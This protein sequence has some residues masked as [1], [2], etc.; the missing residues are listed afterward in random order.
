MVR[1]LKSKKFYL[2]I[3]IPL[4]SSILF[5]FL[6]VQSSL[7]FSTE[8]NKQVQFINKEKLKKHVKHLSEIGSRLTLKLE[9]PHYD[10]N[11]RDQKIEY[12]T[13]E[14]K[15][16][17]YAITKEEFKK[18]IRPE[19]PAV[20]GV[21]LFATKIGSKQPK[22]IIEI[23]AHYD[24]RMDS[25]GADDNCSGISAL[26]EIAHNLKVIQTNKTI[27]ICFFDL[28]EYGLYG[29]REHVRR[30]KE[31]TNE[32]VEE[33]IVLEMI[34]YS[35]DKEKS[36]KTP[37]RIP[38]FVDPPETGNFISLMSNWDSR[39]IAYQFEDA[40]K[41]YG[42]LPFFGLKILGGFLKEKDRSDHYPYWLSNYK[43]IMITDTANFRNHHYHQKTDV[44]TT[45]NYDFMHKV[46]ISI[47]AL[48]LHRS[49]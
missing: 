35:S 18:V 11:K 21:N 20:I 12:I 29:S 15:A 17:G 9:K 1:I 45:L 13:N 26:L 44:Y 43:A 4:L 47:Y 22:N 23:G 39:D 10:K 31:N 48:L 3:F 24:T 6:V 38:L 27:R 49:K 7:T 34:G 14:L 5:Y 16:S 8:I 28:E 30:I 36:Q 32:T 41:I 19:L 46:T 40:A 2:A 33:I 25:P 42:K 37:I